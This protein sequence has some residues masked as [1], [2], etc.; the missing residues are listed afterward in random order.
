MVRV[1]CLKWMCDG[2]PC[3]CSLRK[4]NVEN[5][6]FTT[7]LIFPIQPVWSPLW[8]L[9]PLCLV[10]LAFGVSLSNLSNCLLYIYVKDT[11]LPLI[12]F[13]RSHITMSMLMGVLYL[14]MEGSF[15]SCPTAMSSPYE[16]QWAHL[17]IVSIIPQ[18]C[19][20]P[21]SLNLLLSILPWTATNWGHPWM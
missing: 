11:V 3:V 19:C 20:C 10:S 6:Q 17:L 12:L 9:Q 7:L 8:R 13:I 1:F 18:A 21:A 5:D 2:L 15:A 4:Q 14:L 16:R